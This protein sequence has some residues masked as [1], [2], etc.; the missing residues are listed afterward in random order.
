[1]TDRFRR[2]ASRL[3]SNLQ[4][5]IFVLERFQIK[6]IRTNSLFLLVMEVMFSSPFQDFQGPW[7]KFK[8][9]PGNGT[10]FPLMATL[11]YTERNYYLL[12]YICLNEMKF[13]SLQLHLSSC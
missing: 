3:I 8:D 6:I 4:S 9:F 11:H 1:M 7:L 5:R 10:F 2:V 12:D 13:L